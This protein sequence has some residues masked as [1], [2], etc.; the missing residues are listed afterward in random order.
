MNT[1]EIIKIPKYIDYDK[2]KNP[3]PKGVFGKEQCRTQE[4]EKYYNKRLKSILNQASSIASTRHYEPEDYDY[5][6]AE[7]VIEIFKLKSES[8]NKSSLRAFKAIIDYYFEKLLQQKRIEHHQYYMLMGRLQ[9]LYRERYKDAPKK[10]VRTSGLKSKR[11]PEHLINKLKKTLI[12]KNN[13]YSML[14]LTMFLMSME[15]G[16]RP[17]EWLTS[18]ILYENFFLEETGQSYNAILKVKNGKNTNGRSFGE[19]RYLGIINGEHL[20]QIEFIIKKSQE[21]LNEGMEKDVL[22]NVL[23]KEMKSA[24]IKT[25][26]KKHITLYTARHQFSANMKNILSKDQIADLMGHGSNETAGIHYGKKRSGHLAYKEASKEAN[27]EV[28]NVSN[29]L[30]ENKPTRLRF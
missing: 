16:L 18:E 22:I 9:D 7:C 26:D 3:N 17:S 12:E 29:T 10:S 13:K 19:Y 6:L 5:V 24:E 11:I 23:G 20:K 14:T 2:N 4:T 15:Y 25:A 21:L 8:Y 28:N 1:N 30:Q 27:K